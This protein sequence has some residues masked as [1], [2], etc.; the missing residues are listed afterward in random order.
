MASE[1]EAVWNEATVS[2]RTAALGFLGYGVHASR[3]RRYANLRWSE[4]PKTVR[5]DLKKNESLWVPDLVDMD[6]RGE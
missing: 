6:V 3:Q 4:L 5:K 1:A 2:R